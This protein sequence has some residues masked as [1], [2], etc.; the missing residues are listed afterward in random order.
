MAYVQNQNP[1]R[2]A[3]TIGAVGVLHAALGYALITGFA[4]TVYKKIDFLVPT[5]Q[6]KDDPPPPP[7]PPQ[8]SVEPSKTVDTKVTAPRADLDL[9]PRE[10]TATETGMFPLG[11]IGPLPGTGDPGPLPP[12]P[13]PSA[14]FTPRGAT[15]LGSPGL[16]VSTDDYPAADLRSEHEGVS[17]FRVTVGSDG[18]VQNCEITRSSGFPGLD[19]AACANVA[20]RARFKP[21]TDETGAVVGGSYSSAVKWEIPG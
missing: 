6:W 7:P 4:A 17:R 21:A 14:S 2:R 10:S 9:A 15:P 1:Q 11:P 12:L 18:R 8:P 16:W 5:R 13:S 19:R 20:K 3:L